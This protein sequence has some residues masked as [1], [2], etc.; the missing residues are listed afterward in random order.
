MMY[1]FYHRHGKVLKGGQK[2]QR[3]LGEGERKHA[4]L[5]YNKRKQV[6]LLTTDLSGCQQ[7]A[8]THLSRGVS[9][10]RQASG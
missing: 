6:A 8:N 9:V 3:D 5:L 10:S 1:Y 4:H 7:G 2:Q